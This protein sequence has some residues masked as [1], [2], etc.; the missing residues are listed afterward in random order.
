MSQRTVSVLMP[1]LNEEK[2]VAAAIGS[3]LAQREV[4]LEVLVIDGRSADGTRAIVTEIAAREPRVRLLDNPQVIIPAALN[5]GLAAATGEFVARVDG[6]ASVSGDY[7]A[8]GV[9]HLRDDPALAAVGG[10]RNGVSS[11]PTGRAVALALSSPFGVGDSIN[12]F[13]THFQRTDHASFGV[14]RTDVARAVG[15]WDESLLVNEDVDFDHRILAAGHEIAFDPAM[16]IFWHV[17][18]NAPALFRQ[19]RRYGRGKAAMA[20]K[21]GRS[22]I[23]PRHLAAP[24]AVLGTAGLAAIAVRHPRFAALAYSPYVVGVTLASVQAWRA[25]GSAPV[26]PATVPLSFMAMHYGW[27]LGFL[28]GYV[29][30]RTPMRASGSAR[31]RT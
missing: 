21:N 7:L 9:A 16:K 29:L 3:V 17:R 14:Y 15:G 5:V 11:T 26:D 6:H 19:Y 4:D 30:G 22:A 28:E 1:V 31:T 23:R 8:L 25:R 13:G 18:D 20:R 24:V 12:H 2:S 10:I 27:G